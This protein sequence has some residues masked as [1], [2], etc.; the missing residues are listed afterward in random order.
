M[1][2][3]VYVNNLYSLQELEDN[4]HRETVNI[5]TQRAPL[6]VKK[7]YLK[8]WGQLRNWRMTSLRLSH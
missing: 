2:D 1:K 7:Y 6:S 5:P 8:M 4:I 3:R